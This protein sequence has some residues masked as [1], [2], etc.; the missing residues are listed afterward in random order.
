M[1]NNNTLCSIGEASCTPQPTITRT[2]QHAT[3]N[4]LLIPWLNYY[5]KNDCNSAF[6]FDSTLLADTAIT[7]LTNCIGCN[8]SAFA[9]VNQTFSIDI[10]PNPFK[11]SFLVNFN[12]KINSTVTFNVF[13]MTGQIFHLKNQSNPANENTF[14]F[15]FPEKL[16]AG[17][18]FLEIITD[19]NRI[20]KKIVKQ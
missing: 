13:N 10:F 12:T 16:P 2:V 9:D 15:I 14:E 1:A 17:I 8:P 7:F 4:K 11:N 3:I 20:I 5:L 18:Y 19:S 6:Q